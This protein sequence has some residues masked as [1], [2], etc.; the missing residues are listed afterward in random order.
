MRRRRLKRT[1]TT[2][3]VFLFIYLSGTA[4]YALANSTLFDITEISVNGYSTVSREEIV[5]YSGARLGA[6]ILQLSS[7]SASSSIQT[8]PYI[9]EAVV[10]ISFPNKVA[11]H[12][13]EREPIAL[14]LVEDRYLIMDAT[15]RCLAEVS[16]AVAGLQLLPVVLGNAYTVSLMPGE[17]STDKGLGAA[18]ALIQRLDPFFMENIREIDALTAEKLA[19]INR[20]G[21]R[22]LFGPPED[23][24]RKL[25]NYEELLL[26]NAE[27]CNA[28]TLNYVDLRYD[29]QITLNWK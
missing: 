1:L 9:K 10:N 6:N 8:L 22:V 20:D 16:Q 7:A 25:Q 2:A 13:T 14:L 29:T 23:L 3:V 27:K 21:L 18:L 12:V 15:G 4:G 11:I 5:A 26:K 19:V 24:E 17:Q 28:D